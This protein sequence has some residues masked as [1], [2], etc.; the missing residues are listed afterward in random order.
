MRHYLIVNEGCEYE[1][2]SCENI[3]NEEKIIEY[4]GGVIVD[5]FDITDPANIKVL[6]CTFELTED[7][8]VDVDKLDADL[9]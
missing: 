7:S 3:L 2:Y 5:I 4:F 1:K 6:A 8:W 9:L